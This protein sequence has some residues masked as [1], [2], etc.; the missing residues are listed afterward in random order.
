MR[1]YILIASA[2]YLMCVMLEWI[3]Q[4][5]RNRLRST[6]YVIDLNSVH[7]FEIGGELQKCIMQIIDTVNNDSEVDTGKE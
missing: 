4:P 2:L 3:E 5:E 7:C 1:P 6:A